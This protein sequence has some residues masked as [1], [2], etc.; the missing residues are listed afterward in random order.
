MS[1]LEILLVYTQYWV[2]ERSWVVKRKAQCLERGWSPGAPPLSQGLWR[3]RP[4]GGLWGALTHGF[5]APTYCHE[6]TR[7]C[8]SALASVSYSHLTR[9]RSLCLFHRQKLRTKDE[10][11]GNE[12]KGKKTPTK[13][14]TKHQPTKT[15]PRYPRGRIRLIQLQSYT[16]QPGNVNSEKAQQMLE[17]VQVF[18]TL[19]SLM[20]A[21]S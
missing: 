1:S 18:W 20:A 8:S 3:F 6:A 15:N 21:C 11:D 14:K 4:A 17:L 9:P 16:K 5:L 10:D 12:R 2:S 7:S 13:T 19:I